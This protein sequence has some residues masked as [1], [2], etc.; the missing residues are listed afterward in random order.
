MKKKYFWLVQ[1]LLVISIATGW[2]TIARAQSDSSQYS[3]VADTWVRETS[4]DNT[5]NYGADTTL[6][7]RNSSSGYREIAFLRFDLTGFSLP[8]NTVI[9]SAKLLLTMVYNQSAGGVVNI[10][11]MSDA[12]DGWNENSITWSSGRPDTVHNVAPLASLA[13]AKANPQLASQNGVI[14][15]WDITSQVVSEISDSNKIL[16]VAV[17]PNYNTAINIKVL[18]KESAIPALRP[19]LVIYTHTIDRNCFA[20]DAASDSY[21]S[22][23]NL[24]WKTLNE[25]DIAYFK[26]LHSID[27]T[28]FSPLANVV[29]TG[30]STD[31]ISYSYR[32]ENPEVNLIHYYKIETVLKDSTHTTSAIDSVS[33]GLTG[34]NSRTDW[35]VTQVPSIAVTQSRLRQSLQMADFNPV[36]LRVEAG[37]PVVLNVQQ[38]SGG[39]LP[40]LR[41]GTFDRQTST[42]YSLTAGVNTITPANDGDLYLQYSSASPSDN[43]KV[44]VT[45][46]SGYKTMPLYIL[47]TTTHQQWLDQLSA[48]TESPNVTL[49]ANRVFIVVSRQQAVNYEN[50]NQDTLLTYIDEIMRAEDEISGLDNSTA[51][52]APAYGNKLMLLE[53]ASGNPDATSYGRVRIPTGSINWILDPSYIGNPGG[54]WGIFHE[55]G[56]H[57]QQTPWS[58]SACTE[59]TVNIYSAA[60]KR[61]F[62]PGEQAIGSSDWNN[63]MAY[64]AQPDSVKNYNAGSM[65]N[66]VK[67][68]MWQQLWLAY[69]DSFYHALHKRTRDEGISPANDS[70]EMRLM[71]RYA[72]EISGENLSRFFKKWGLPLDQASFDAIDAMGYPVPVTDPST[73]REDWAVH[74]TSPVDNER[75]AADKDTVL[76]TA[77]AYGPEGVSKVAFY[78]GNT[79]LGEATE[80]PYSFKWANVAPGTYAISAKAISKSGS[81]INSDTISF[82]KESI[83]ITLP[84]TNTSFASGSN[85][86]IQARTDAAGS[87]VSKVEFYANG[88]KVGESSAA[89]YSFLWSN[90]ANGIYRLMAKAI[91]QDAG[92]DTSAD[93]AVAVGGLFP[94]ADA[95][96]R[97]GSANTN[98]GEDPGLVVK[99]D[100]SGYN[101]KTYLRFDLSG[102]TGTLDSAKLVLNISS[103]NTSA[104]SVQW[105]LWK[106]N[107]DNWKEDSITWNNMPATDS[108]LG[109]VQGKRSGFVVWDITDVANAELA[110]DK[111]LTLAVVSS[112]VNQL[113]DVTFYSKEADAI[114]LRPQLVIRQGL[115]G[116]VMPATLSPLTAAP[117]EKEILLKWKTSTELNAASFELQRNADYNNNFSTI[118]ILKAKDNGQ[119]NSYSYAD[120]NVESGVV[121]YYRLKALS[122]DGTY[123]YSAIA[124]ASVNGHTKRIIVYPNPLKG[125]LLN[126]EI[127][128]AQSTSLNFALFNI[129]GKAVY[130]AAQ[131]VPSGKNTVSI[132]L[133]KLASGIY[134]LHVFGV[135]VSDSEAKVIIR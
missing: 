10:L 27:G 21:N 104:G 133:P 7:T 5:N 40:S 117:V 107:E 77:T 112:T 128:S 1:V 119:S 62:H 134:M 6:T 24:Q 123:F 89:P 52:H 91:Y 47:G 17:Y 95:Y 96:V 59:V 12:N 70:D 63:V 83:S 37:V 25:A 127:Q 84:V 132:R 120:N 26:V 102:Y 19:R 61:F 106:C 34:M 85:I 30:T 42:L 109:S 92:S 115:S 35:S 22:S 114:T 15:S 88:S 135:G 65:D 111:I 76:I 80:A 110:G 82:T 51:V 74:V 49:I 94:A 97:D 31:T 48:D 32:H 105:Q 46:Q 93:V 103:A 57:H 2:C 81:V 131:N 16:S 45:F 86:N 130:R 20:L 50:A 129:N 43:N 39:G 41:I 28:N 44:R 64:L 124:T 18:S 38:V 108:L 122:D 36:G 90:P 79:K 75:V 118:T 98:F 121:Y 56:H 4:P 116:I 9:D 78:R 73:L 69:G 101:R 72:T 60:A 53:K 99:T 3:P 126:A 125:N 23:I 113:S 58:W 55:M 66:Y 67:L 11:S 87:A 54:G 29:A 100:A 33:Y 8:A 13:V 71:M 68:G 14:Y